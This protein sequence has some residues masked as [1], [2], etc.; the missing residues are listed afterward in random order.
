MVVDSSTSS[1]SSFFLPFFFFFLLCLLVIIRNIAKEGFTSPATHK[2][3]CYILRSTDSQHCNEFCRA[4]RRQ[5]VQTPFSPKAAGQEKAAPLDLKLWRQDRTH[6]TG[7]KCHQS[8]F[9]SLVVPNPNL[10][11]VSKLK[12]SGKWSP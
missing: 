2:S 3:H 4:G 9:S 7:V 10:S 12:V 5:E 1:T 6:Q 8:T 11:N